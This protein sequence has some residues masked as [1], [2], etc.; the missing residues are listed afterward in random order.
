MRIKETKVYKY[1]E[2][3]DAAKEKARDW[4]REASAGDNF[5]AECVTDSFVEELNALG[6]DTR[7]KDISWSGFWLQGDGAAFGGSWRACDFKPDALLADRLTEYPGAKP[8]CS[9]KELHRIAAEIR[10]CKDAG[11]TY[12]GISVSNRGFY[13]SLDSA[14]HDQPLS[15]EDSDDY[16]E[17]CADNEARFIEAARDLA[18]AFYKALESECEYVNSDE[19][20]AENIEVNEYEFTEDGRIA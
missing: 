4:Y 8:D 7:E 2:L 16:P 18:R 3:S 11:L 6:F 9:N 1:A 5:F 19:V 20:V 12:A 17:V 10:A 14:E 13:M 15:V